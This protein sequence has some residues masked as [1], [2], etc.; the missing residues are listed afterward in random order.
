MFIFASAYVSGE[1]LSITYALVSPMLSDQFGFTVENTALY[2]VG[3][4]VGAFF[5]GFVQ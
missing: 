3:L 4:A 5:S 1:V 2:F